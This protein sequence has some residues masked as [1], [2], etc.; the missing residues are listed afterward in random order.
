VEVA[1]KKVHFWKKKKEQ[2]SLKNK[3]EFVKNF[4]LCHEWE[5]SIEKEIEAKLDAKID[6]KIKRQIKLKSNW[7]GQ[8]SPL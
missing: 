6:I 1:P 3:F 8:M 7:I 4:M 5:K 2:K